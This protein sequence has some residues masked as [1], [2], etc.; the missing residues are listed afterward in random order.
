MRLRIVLL[1][2]LAL[3]SGI[4]AAA[5]VDPL[6]VEQRAKVFE[7]SELSVTRGSV[8]R[9]NNDDP[10]IHHIF[11]ESPNFNF[12]SGDHRPGKIV[13]IKFD[14]PGDYTVQCAIHLKMKLRV[15][16]R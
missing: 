2:T 3:L 14:E 10:F 1:F 11:V 8:V 16:V 7:P 5:A 6:R 4:A 13:E 9:I 12:D 15:A